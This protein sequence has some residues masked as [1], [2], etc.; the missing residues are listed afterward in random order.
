MT[1][2]RRWKL[3]ASLVCI[4]IALV[5]VEPVATGQGHSAESSARSCLDAAKKALGPEAV[6]AKC[7]RLTG[8]TGLEVVGVIRL[9]QF[10]RTAD[11]GIPVSKLVVLRRVTAS[12]WRTELT[13]D[14]VCARNNVGYLGD[15]YIDNLPQDER[16]HAGYY[17]RFSSYIDEEEKKTGFAM[18]FQDL[19]WDR[20]EEEE[21]TSWEIA[22][23][24]LV[25]RFQ[26]YF[27]NE[28]PTGFSQ[29]V[30]TLPRLS[31]YLKSHGCRG[32][33]KSPCDK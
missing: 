7:G 6:V 24:P 30:K 29:E 3:A 19:R 23:N 31:D 2:S 18:V 8:P 22:W 10:R 4:F 5:R 1:S 9:R 26:Y 32:A 13:V 28:D 27:V 15:G 11:G 33:E 20:N 25:G 12:Q 21:G 16:L 17:V 14:K